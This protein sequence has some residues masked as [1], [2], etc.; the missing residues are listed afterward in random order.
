MQSPWGDID[1]CDAHVH[2]FSYGFFSALATLVSARGGGVPATVESIATTLGWQAPPRE[3]EPLASIWIEEL[4]RQGVERAALIASVPG[5]EASVAAAVRSYPNRF[6]GYFMVDPTAAGAT[7]RVRAA[8]EGGHLHCICLFPAMHRYSIQDER[9]RALLDAAAGHPG[10]A[11]FVHCGVLSV[12]VRAK[13]GLPSPFDMRFSNPIDLHAV[14]LAFPKL[15]FIIPHFGAGYFREALMICDLCP[16]VYLDTSSSNSWI[17]YQPGPLDLA[18]VFRRA[19]N[20][21]GPERL[22]FGSDSAFFPRGW[23]AAIFA[24]Q[25]EA[26]QQIAISG[27]DARRIFGGNLTRMLLR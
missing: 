12:G 15:H 10:V 16:N 5:D 19:L 18:G 14:A 2:F 17:R 7:E 9:V 22:L 23:N 1:V 13:L 25:V 27:P 21:A 26:L 11:I 20:V 24:A 3:P 4:D 8:L 6:Y